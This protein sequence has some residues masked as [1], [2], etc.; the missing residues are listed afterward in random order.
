MYKK[1]IKA[2]PNH[3]NNLGN[4]SQIL[5]IQGDTE[6]IEY[7]EKAEKSQH[8]VPELQL[9]LL[10]YR[11]VHIEQNRKI[12]TTMKELLLDDV[13]SEGWDL[14]DNVSVACKS[15]HLECKML[16]VIAKVI[17]GNVDIEKLEE[18]ETWKKA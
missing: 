11:Y 15:G 4:L 18:F 2:D 3:A 17:A 1:A 6:A 7:L 12:L 14:S 10:F 8:N 13:R 5:F 9:E 16:E